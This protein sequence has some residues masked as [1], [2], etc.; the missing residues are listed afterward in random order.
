MHTKGLA[1]I[2]KVHTFLSEFKKGKFYVNA[3][4]HYIF[5]IVVSS[6][7]V[8]HLCMDEYI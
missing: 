6:Q 5:Y 2:I 4:L 8:L 3:N 1:V 7:N